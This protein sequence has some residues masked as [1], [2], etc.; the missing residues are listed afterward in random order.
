MSTMTAEEAR[1]DCIAKM[2]HALGTQF[3]ELWQEVA[4]VHMKWDE[5]RVLYATKESRIALLNQAAPRFFRLVQDVML[6]DTLLHI[7]RIMDVRKDVLTVRRLPK[8]VDDPTVRCVLQKLVDAAVTKCDFCKDWR[9]RHIAHRNLA[10]AI[11]PESVKPLKR[12]DIKKVDEALDS[13]VAVLNAVSAHYQDSES[14]F[15]L[16]SRSGGAESL[17]YVLDS[18]VR[19]EA[20]REER[21][22]SCK[23]T[24]EDYR[25]PRAL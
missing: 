22:A 14:F 1:Q 17:L 18:G 10:L 6:E 24:E 21:I 16:G 15:R 25:R 12:A 11:N 19:A 5:F 9:D 23:A 4:S 7:S 13:I 8:Y 2:G 20:A 3:S